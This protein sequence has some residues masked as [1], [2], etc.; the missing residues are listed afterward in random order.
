MSELEIIMAVLAIVLPL[1]GA[2]WA[3]DIRSS[4]RTKKVYEQLDHLDDCVDALKVEQAASHARLEGQLTA[5]RD[6]FSK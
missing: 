5:I 1:G 2:L 6:W 4:N 3:L